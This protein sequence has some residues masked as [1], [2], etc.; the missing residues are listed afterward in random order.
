MPVEERVTRNGGSYS[1]EHSSCAP[2]TIDDE[3]PLQQR[4]SLSSAVYWT[5]GNLAGSSV[6]YNE[7]DMNGMNQIRFQEIVLLNYT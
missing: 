5:R 3:G 1:Q 6:T 4:L 7:W 2:A